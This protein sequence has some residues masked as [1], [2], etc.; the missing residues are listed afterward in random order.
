M[1]K[2]WQRAGNKNEPDGTNPD[3][4]RIFFKMYSIKLRFNQWS[5]RQEVSEVSQNAYTPDEERT[6]VPLTD[7][8]LK[9]FMTLAGDTQHQFRPTEA[10]FRRT[11]EVIAH[12]SAYDPVIEKLTALQQAWDGMSRLDYWLSK[13]CGVPEDAYHKAVGRNVAGGMVRR[14]RHPG[15]KHDEV[16]LLISPQ[17][18]N[19]STL[20]RIIALDDEWFTDSVDFEGSPQNVLP[21]L[22]GKLVVELAELDGMA[23]REITHIKRFMTTQSDN[24]T[25]KFQALAR[26]YPRRNIFVGTT[27]DVA[28][29][30]DLTGN[31]RWLPVDV[32][33]EIDTTWLRAN[34]PQILAEAATLEAAGE[35]FAIPRELWS[36]AREKQTAAT[37][38]PPWE[39]HLREWFAESPTPVYITASDLLTLATV[40]NGGRA[41]KNSEYINLMTELKFVERTWRVNGKPAKV[42]CRGDINVAYRIIPSVEHGRT[43]PRLFMD[44]STTA[45]TAPPPPPTPPPR[46]EPAAP[47]DQPAPAPPPPY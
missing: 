3:N 13:A 37:E 21:Q 34:W 39:T 15:C 4:V 2:D 16:M 31:R 46:P 30:R 35:T 22:F 7:A 26:D 40:A 43:V 33:N 29:L 1:F 27:N 24:F 12:E 32:Q 14:A 45:S 6:W 5:V 23:K 44:G 47:A 20:C 11:T 36:K 10:L 41:P 42:R 28:P 9:R 25:M 18:F 17:G 8:I 19:K 38:R